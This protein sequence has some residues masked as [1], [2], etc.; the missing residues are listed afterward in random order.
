MGTEMA[1]HPSDVRAWAQGAGED[2]PARGRLSYGAVTAYLKAN[3]R[4]TRELAVEYGV[5]VPGRGAVS[6]AACEELA[7]LVR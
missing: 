7:V 1:Y 6:M 4:V 2:V 5:D 3:P